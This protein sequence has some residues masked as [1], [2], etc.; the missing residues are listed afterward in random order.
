MW[1]EVWFVY[2]VGIVTGYLSIYFCIAGWLICKDFG[3]G[4]F[5]QEFTKAITHH[6]FLELQKRKNKQS[7]NLTICKELKWLF[8]H[9][10][11]H[12]DFLPPHLTIYKT[13]IHKL[14]NQSSLFVIIGKYSVQKPLF[15]PHP[16][17]LKPLFLPYFFGSEKFAVV[18]IIIIFTYLL[19]EY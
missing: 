7:Y 18:M 8:F 3:C 5:S 2:Q 14:M 16:Q 19:V 17:I 13:Q 9:T 1:N 15:L 6:F 12:S 4:S 11:Q 10:L